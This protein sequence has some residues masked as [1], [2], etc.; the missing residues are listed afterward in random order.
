MTGGGGV[1]GEIPI[2]LMLSVNL[3]ENIC[4]SESGKQSELLL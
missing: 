4:R 3:V 1:I 2:C